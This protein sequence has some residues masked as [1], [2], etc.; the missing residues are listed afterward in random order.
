MNTYKKE[1]F[2][3]GGSVFI[4][5]F[6]IGNVATL[7]HTIDIEE[8]SIKA[9]A[10]GG[11]YDTYS[12][13]N[14]VA[15]ELTVHDLNDDNLALAMQALK[16]M[17]PGGTEITEPETVT[18]LK[19]G[20]L[21]ALNFFVDTTATVTVTDDADTPQSFTAGTDFEVT[22]NGIKTLKSGAITAGTVLKV[23]YTPKASTVLEALE[24]Q[25]LEAPLTVI[26]AN[27]AQS[28]APFNI[29]YHKVKIAPTASFAPFSDDFAELPLAGEALADSTKQGGKSKFMRMVK[30]PSVEA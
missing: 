1:T 10:T 26:G 24:G 13:V 3:G 14:A 30:T 15:I 18:A 20:A 21:H 22:V 16:I 9:R 25:Q 6:D 23:T 4:A 8:K 5:G 11:K 28:G 2:I 27:E 17:E 29:Q 7:T 12:Q 19:P